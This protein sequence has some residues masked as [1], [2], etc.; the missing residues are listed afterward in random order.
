MRA[1]DIPKTGFSTPFGN[2]EF[3]VM[4]MGLCGAPGTFQ[5][6]MDDSFAAPIQ[7]H[8]RA[9]SFM[10]FLCV[11]LD[12]LCVHSATRSEHLLH[13]RCVLLRLRERKLYVKPTKCE[14]MCQQ[15]EFLGHTVGP[16][17]MCITSAK[18]DALQQWPEPKTVSEIRSLLGTF[19]FW[20]MYIRD[21][22]AITQ[23]LTVLT[24][25]SVAWHWG[26]RE[27]A[28]L[29]DLKRAVRES[30]VLKPPQED[31]PY[32]I[33]TDAS[34]YAIG[35]SLEQL[36][37]VSGKRRPV[38]FFSHLL[39]PAEC[40]Y[41]THE[42]ELLA[43]VLALRTW[44]HFLLGSEFSVVYQTDHRPLQSFLQQTTLSARQVRWQQFLSEFNFTVRQHHFDLCVCVTQKFFPST[45]DP[46]KIM[47]WQKRDNASNGA[48]QAT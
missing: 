28:A 23:P 48:L 35:V 11:Y 27:R 34:D 39:S 29:A 17:G 21:Y 8:G 5:H 30:P 20:R 22:A 9:M 24:R 37:D 12:D 33:V 16:R 4:P 32:F 42:H 46:S 25:K 40:S 6:L 15:I 41:P 38:A 45:S 10:D 19:G 13:L 2:F 26:E 7:L 47:K 44:R 43:I 3:R 31:K 14:W 36:D 18:V 1:S